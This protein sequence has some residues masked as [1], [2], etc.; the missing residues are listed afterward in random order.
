MFWGSSSSSSFVSLIIIWCLVLSIHIGT[1]ARNVEYIYQA[2]VDLV[3]E[4]CS[5]ED[6][7]T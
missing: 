6:P 2:I 4:G 7:F 1:L 3:G 5:L